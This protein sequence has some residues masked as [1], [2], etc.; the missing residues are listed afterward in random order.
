MSYTPH[1]KKLW[2]CNSF[3]LGLLCV[4]YNASCVQGEQVKV[5][6]VYIF[7][8]KL[9]T[10]ELLTERRAV[11]YVWSC[12]CYLSR[13]LTD[14]F[15]PRRF[16]SNNQID[17]DPSANYSCTVNVCF[18]K[19]HLLQI[20]INRLVSKQPFESIPESFKFSINDEEVNKRSRI[21]PHIAP[22]I[23]V[24]KSFLNWPHL[25]IFSAV[26]IMFL[27]WIFHDKL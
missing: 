20:L 21:S 11:P 19:Y 23:I 22:S 2:L 6:T 18:D 25:V 7:Q 1:A 27:M 9:F 16:G 15:F 8:E 17:I 24:F 5:I 3:Y 26:V 14:K 4:K 13:F 10:V 12:L